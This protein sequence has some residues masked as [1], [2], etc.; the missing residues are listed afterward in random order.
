MTST[1]YARLD[2]HRAA[3][4]PEPQHRRRR[5]R[6]AGGHQRRARPAA[7][8]PAEQAD[9]PQGQSRRRADPDPRAHLRPPYAGREMYDAA[10]SILAA[11]AL[12]DRGRRPGRRR[13]QRAAR[14]ARRAQSDAAEQQSASASRTCE[15]LL[16]NANANRPKGE[17]ANDEQTWA[18]EHDRPAAQGRGLPA[19][20]R[21]AT[22]TAPPFGLP[23]SAR[24]TRLGRGRP[25]NAGM[26]DGKPAVLVIIFRQPGA[27]IIDTV[28]RVYAASAAAARLD[29]GRDQSRPSSSTAPPPSAPRSTT[30]SSR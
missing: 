9:L 18:L 27:N 8:Q 4:R 14:R 13:R 3:V 19:A 1:S 23:T 11:E 17:L 22:T 24:S 12:A 29:P 7:G 6:R 26:V 15:R 20:D 5:A 10:D 16:A 21:R 30:S 25:R 28:D 2:Q